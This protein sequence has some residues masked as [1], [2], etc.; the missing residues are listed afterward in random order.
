MIQAAS[1]NVR[2]RDERR[3][4]PVYCCPT[5]N[6]VRV[7]KGL[8]DAGIECPVLAFD[9]ETIQRQGVPFIDCALEGEFALPVSVPGPPPRIIP[10]DDESPDRAFDDIVLTALIAELSKKRTDVMVPVLA[11]QALPHLGVYAAAARNRLIKKVD[12]AVRRIADRDQTSFEYLRKTGNREYAVMRF[13][14][15]PEDSAPQGRTQVYQAIL[16]SHRRRS[17]EAPESGGTQMKLFDEMMDE[18]LQVDGMMD[19]REGQE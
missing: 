4:Q 3:I 14:K 5:E 12:S 1:I 19:R 15:S 10:V 18:F 17:D 9:D 13:L 11:A 6:V 8:R 2:I 7:M 16:R